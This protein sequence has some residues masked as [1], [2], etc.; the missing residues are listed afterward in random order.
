MEEWMYHP[1][2]QAVIADIC[3]GSAPADCRLTTTRML[4]NHQVLPPT[5]VY[6]LVQWKR[7]KL[8]AEHWFA[9]TWALTFMAAMMSLSCESCHLADDDDCFECGATSRNLAWQWR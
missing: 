6:A 8:R 1:T 7:G 5:A 3:L 2:A 9:P 4:W